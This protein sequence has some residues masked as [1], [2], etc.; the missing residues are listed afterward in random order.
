VKVRKLVRKVG[1]YDNHRHEARIIIDGETHGI[2]VV[3][4]VIG[5]DPV[6][7][8]IETRRPDEPTSTVLTSELMDM[9]RDRDQHGKAEIYHRSEP[10]FVEAWYEIDKVLHDDETDITY[11]SAGDVIATGS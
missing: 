2:G 9:L 1:K 6:W 7:A 3:G 10:G 8:V 4:D 5:T 11:L